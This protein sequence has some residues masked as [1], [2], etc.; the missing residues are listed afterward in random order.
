LDYGC[1]VGRLA[2]AL[3]ERF[4]CF[5][6][7]ADISQDMRGLAP[8]YVNSAAFSVL[9]RRVLQR[10]AEGGLR[11]DAAFSAWVLQHCHQ[12]A[13]D[14]QLIRGAL[15]PGGPLFIA[16]TLGR[17]VPTAE[18]RWASDGIDVRAELSATFR[19]DAFGRLAEE[20]VGTTISSVT[21]WGV[22]R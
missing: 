14:I 13:E 5:V 9:S 19:E 2:K 10:L 20:S 1:G 21:F 11:V 15:K 4:D 18:Q 17:A 6:V 16:N 3:I 22:Y 12:P 8:G 7:G